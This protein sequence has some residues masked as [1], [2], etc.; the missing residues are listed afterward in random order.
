M[1]FHTFGAMHALLEYQ[2]LTGD[3]DLKAALIRMADHY[4]AQKRRSYTF[5]KAVAFAA[6]HAADPAP[7]RKVLDDWMR[8]GASY[9]LFHMVTDTPKHWTGET[10]LLRPGVSGQWFWL[11]DVFY[12]LARLE[13]EPEPT[14]EQLADFARLNAVGYRRGFARESWQSD[15]DRPDLADYLRDRRRER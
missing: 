15:Y 9:Q 13:R 7:Y 10:A 12:V 11:N 4:V 8:S 2:Y 5:R 14:A 3:P 1:F 6:M